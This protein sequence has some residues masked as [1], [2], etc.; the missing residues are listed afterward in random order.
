[1]VN[2]N[3]RKRTAATLL[4]LSLLAGCGGGEPEANEDAA[5]AVVVDLGQ[6]ANQAMGVAS[7]VE[8]TASQLSNRAVQ[9]WH[10]RRGTQDR[11]PRN[12]AEDS[13]NAGES[14][15]GDAPD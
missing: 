9:A 11:E 12:S 3:R 8:A 5:N 14:P 6:A 1:M 7:S 10:E 15:D 2:K 4:G 13:G